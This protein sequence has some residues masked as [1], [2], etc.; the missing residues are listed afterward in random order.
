MPQTHE[1]RPT[2]RVI[3]SHANRNHEHATVNVITSRAAD[4][5]NSIKTYLQAPG[6]LNTTFKTF[7]YSGGTNV[8]GIPTIH[9][10]GFTAAA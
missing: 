2:V 7:I 6:A 9:I 1:P 4:V 5:G 10:A 8:A 3:A